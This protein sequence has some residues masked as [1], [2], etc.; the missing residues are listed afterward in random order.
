MRFPFT[1]RR[2]VASASGAVALLMATM[3]LAASSSFPAPR[4]VIYPGDRI[5]DSMLEDL[6]LSTQNGADRGFIEAR[7]QVVGKIARRT[8]LPGQP[9]PAAA[10][11]NP[12][13]INIGT[14]VKIVFSEDGLV[15]TAVGMALQAGGVGDLIR[16]RNQDSGLMVSGVIQADGSIRVSEG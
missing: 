12:R 10:I 5:D 16:V 4:A 2:M 3:S 9:I 8:L 11:D 14:A 7:T 13:L 1:L 15:I 6:S